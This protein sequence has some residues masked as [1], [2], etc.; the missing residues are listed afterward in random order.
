MKR[1]FFTIFFGL[2]LF[3]G[4]FGITYSVSASYA[5]CGDYCDQTPNKKGTY[6]GCAC[7]PNDCAGTVAC[8]YC[9]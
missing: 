8:F 9:S 2:F 6:C 5:G 1:K 7:N 4:S 3:V